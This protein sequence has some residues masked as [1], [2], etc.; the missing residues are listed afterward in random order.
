MSDWF[1]SSPTDWN[2]QTVAEQQHKIRNQMVSASGV[3]RCVGRRRP[4]ISS[5]SSSSIGLTADLSRKFLHRQVKV[6]PEKPYCRL[7]RPACQGESAALT[8][9]LPVQLGGWGGALREPPAHRLSQDAGG[10]RN[11]WACLKRGLPGGEQIL[12][13]HAV[14]CFFFCCF[15]S[16]ALLCPHCSVPPSPLSPPRP[17]CHVSS[18]S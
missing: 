14:N 9:T 3:N 4:D 12:R 17:V 2:H 6:F 16:E 1:L 18:L 13:F 7:L 11:I 8:W 15:F 10:P 5:S